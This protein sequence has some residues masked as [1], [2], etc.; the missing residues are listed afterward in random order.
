MFLQENLVYSV[1]GCSSTEMI[2]EIINRHFHHRLRE[3][4][5][6]RIIKIDGI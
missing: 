2:I 3:Y 5:D 4:C 6:K 1:K